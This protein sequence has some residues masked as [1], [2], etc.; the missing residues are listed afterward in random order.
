MDKKLIIFI[1][2]FIIIIVFFESIYC[3]TGCKKTIN[4]ESGNKYEGEMY[5]N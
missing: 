4:L 2:I 1:V 5:H 3:F